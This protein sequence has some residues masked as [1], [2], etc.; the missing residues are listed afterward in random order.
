[1]YITPAWADFLCSISPPPQLDYNSAGAEKADVGNISS[2]AF[3]RRAVPCWR[4]LEQSCSDNPRR[5]NRVAATIARHVPPLR[6]Q[7]ADAVS[8]S[9]ERRR[10]PDAER[11]RRVE[12]IVSALYNT[13][14]S[15][16]SGRLC[17]HEPL[18]VSDLIFD[19]FFDFFAVF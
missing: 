9:S 18:P 19:V 5:R 8:T 1:M 11:A 10:H 12:I 7:L 3:Q 14:L 4:P 13:P 16:K 6:A 15:H 17:L 2:R